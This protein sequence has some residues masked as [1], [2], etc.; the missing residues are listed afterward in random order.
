[1]VIITKNWSAL[2][3]MVPTI[4]PTYTPP[5]D[6]TQQPTANTYTPD[7]IQQP[8]T[9]LVELPEITHDE[10]EG[11]KIVTVSPHSLLGLRRDRKS[12]SSKVFLTSSLLA[13]HP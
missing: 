2:P 5:P 11:T 8:A 3:V 7:N 12:F 10:T 6:S 4:T 13:C 9:D 1:M